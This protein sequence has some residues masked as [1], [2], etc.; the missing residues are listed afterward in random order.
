MKTILTTL[1]IALM[2]FVFNTS[3]F[4]GAESPTKFIQK[5]DELPDTDQADNER[6]VADS[7]NEGSTSA[8]QESDQ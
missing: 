4:A 5:I 6:D 7:G 8:A 1:A 3:A 2:A